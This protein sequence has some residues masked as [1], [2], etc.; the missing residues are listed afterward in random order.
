M[1]ELNKLYNVDCLVAMKKIPDK[2]FELAIVDPPYFNGPNKRR[3]YGR[4]INKLNIKRKIYSVIE[5]WEVPNEEYFQELMRVSKNQIVWGC[6][7][8][9]YY[10]G[11]GR[12]IWDKVNGK[13]S[14]SDCEIAYCSIHKKTKMF[15]YMWNGM[16]QGKSINEGHLMQGDKSKNEVRIH[17]TQKPVNLYKWL[18]L[19]YAKK[20]DKIL[21][22][23]VGSAS[24]LIACHDMG[25]NFLG[26]EKNKEIFKLASKRL[27]SAMNQL[28]IFNII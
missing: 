11:P 17:P 15:R 9:D 3:F 2:Y 20:G 24:S 10:L 28:S 8:Y 13:S 14:F 27:D 26:F 12:I 5:E 19:E 6:N 1:Y 22:T 21:D 4:D 25:F 23:H 7:Y 16:M 18:L